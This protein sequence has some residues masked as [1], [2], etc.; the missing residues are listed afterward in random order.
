MVNHPSENVLV[1]TQAI[2][3]CSNEKARC[4]IEWLSP[5][6]D[7]SA[8]R[9]YVWV[10]LAREIDNRN[11]DLGQAACVGFGQPV[12]LRE[13]SSQRLMPCHKTPNRLSGGARMEPRSANMERLNNVIG[14]VWRIEPLEEPQARLSGGGL[15]LFY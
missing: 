8:H 10:S 9:F 15:H 2:D 13:A 12:V 6:I 1:R 14:T 7:D 4:Q 3:C 5:Q 11:Q